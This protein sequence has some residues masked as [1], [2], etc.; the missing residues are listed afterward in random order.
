[1]SYYLEINRSTGIERRDVKPAGHV[2][3]ASGECPGCGA[4]PFC[5]QGSSPRRMPDDRTI[6][7][8]GRCVSCGDAVGYLYAQPDTIF[9]LEEDERVMHGRARVY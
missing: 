2:G 6:R 7:S 9:G 8:G 4:T 1:M 5:V 3:I